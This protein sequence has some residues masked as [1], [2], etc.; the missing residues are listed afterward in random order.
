MTHAED[1]IALRRLYADFTAANLAPLWTQREGL[2]PPVPT[3]PARPYRWKWTDTLPLARRA[4]EL[5]PVGRGGERRAIAFANPGLGGEPYATPTLW[6][7]VQYLGRDEAAPAHRHSQNAFRFVLEGEG[8]WTVVDGDPVAMRRG[9]LLLTAGWGWHE[10]HNTSDH[11]MVWL[12]GLDMP[13]VGFLDAPFFE[14]GPDEVADRSTPRVSRAEQLWAHPGLR[15]LGAPA[16]PASPLA[17]YRW[18]HTDAALTA[19]LELEASGHAGVA[20]PG[21]AAVRFVNPVNGRDALPTIRT[22]FHR[23]LAGAQTAPRRAVGSTVWQVFAGEGAFTCDGETIPVLYGDVIA[24]PSWCNLGITAA[25][26]ADLDLFVFGDA[27]VH[28]A[29]YLDR[30]D[31]DAR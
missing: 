8:V 27:P 13:L 11:P 25:P 24:V 29:L 5:V 15:P 19:Q 1:D 9:D 20:S 2:M 16:G 18:E 14:Y 23:L 12:D 28:E 17:A 4:G 10:H 30:T 6:A 22:E 7:A 31:K 26:G 3:S 21:H